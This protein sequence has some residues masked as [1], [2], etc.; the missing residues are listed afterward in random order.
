MDVEFPIKQLDSPEGM[1]YVE[2]G[3]IMGGLHPT[4]ITI[5]STQI[6]FSY[7]DVSRDYMVTK[8]GDKI[9]KIIANLDTIYIIMKLERN[10][11]FCFCYF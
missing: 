1:F 4:T 10:K 7:G 6:S 11:A 9:T 8:T 2:N 3:V 5:S